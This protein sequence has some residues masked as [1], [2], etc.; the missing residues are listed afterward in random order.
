MT[1]YIILEEE[2]HSVVHLNFFKNF[3][4][5]ILLQEYVILYVCIRNYT[6]RNNYI[7]VCYLHFYLS[8]FTQC[9]LIA[10]YLAL[11]PVI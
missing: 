1:I 8:F 7:I 4:F 5:Y 10:S 11:K 3:S 9:V 6:K 2:Y